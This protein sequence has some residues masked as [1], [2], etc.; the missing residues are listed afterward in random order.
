MKFII[1]ILSLMGLA[2]C[3]KPNKKESNRSE[4]IELVPEPDKDLR[5]EWEKAQKSKLNHS[6]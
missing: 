1:Y 4:R 2:G 6:I 5:L 3:T